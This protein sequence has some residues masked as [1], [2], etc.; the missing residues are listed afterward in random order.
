MTGRQKLHLL[1]LSIA[2]IVNVLL[3]VLLIPKMGILGA[4]VATSVA[5]TLFSLIAVLQVYRLLKIHPYRRDFYKPV[6]AG[7]VALLFVYIFSRVMTNMMSL[8][9]L[10]LGAGIFFCIYIVVM[11][12]LGLQEE[13]KVVITKVMDKIG[14]KKNF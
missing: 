7:T 5:F 6:I 13:D 10:F 1:N 11:F 9:Y 12:L 3:N 2:L 8:P 4:A 14:R